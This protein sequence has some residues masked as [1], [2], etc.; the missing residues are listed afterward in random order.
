MSL[1]KL[2]TLCSSHLS[3]N[4]GYAVPFILTVIGTRW[5]G[6]TDGY[7]ALFEKLPTNTREL[8][9]TPIA[10]ARKASVWLESYT[11]GLITC[12]MLALK[13]FAGEV[14]PSG[15]ETICP[16]CNGTTESKCRDCDGTGQ[17]EH[18]CSECD[19][20]HSSVCQ[21]CMGEGM[22]ARC[23]G[24]GSLINS[25]KPRPGIVA[26]VTIDLVRLARLLSLC[27]G[28]EVILDT[29][30]EGCELS[31]W[32]PDGSWHARLATLRTQEPDAPI[33]DPNTI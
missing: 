4:S 25:P 24:T 14:L 1:E 28:H 30:S 17:D 7:T 33:F 5:Y 10:I 3:H 20:Q 29:D 8:D 16:N 22:C 21:T 15:V 18:E 32:A 23:E 2:Q 19:N 6:A 31:I 12:D 9:T 13:K 26:E 27:D 11:P